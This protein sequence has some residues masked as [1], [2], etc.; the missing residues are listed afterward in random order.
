MNMRRANCPV[1]RHDFVISDGGDNALP[2]CS[3]RCRDADLHRWF[4]EG[5]PVPVEGERL[6]AEALDEL[7]A[8]E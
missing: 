1:C 8:E 7:P 2:F 5:Y 4:S 3:R 6:A